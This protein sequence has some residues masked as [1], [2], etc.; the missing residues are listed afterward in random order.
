MKYSTK[1]LFFKALYSSS[2][3]LPISIALNLGLVDW[4]KTTVSNNG[5]IEAALILSIPFFIAS[6][7]RIFLIDWVYNQYNINIEP[8]HIIKKLVFILRGANS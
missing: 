2:L 4:I 5:H 7:F 1:S 8:T 6:V 3:G